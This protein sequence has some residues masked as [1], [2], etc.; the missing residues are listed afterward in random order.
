MSMQCIFASLSGPAIDLQK[1]KLI[2]PSRISEDRIISRK[3]DV[4]WLLRSCDLTPL[5]YYLCSA[6]KD[7]C[8][9]DQPKTIDALKDNIREA[10]G[11]IQLLT[12][13][14]VLKNCSDH[15]GYCMASR[16][17]HLNEIIFHYEPK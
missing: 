17:S 2:L 3:A 12:N 13:D 10:I 1:M 8:Y 7:K 15:V 9:T 4:L 14:N 11:E 5:D 16:G 6:V